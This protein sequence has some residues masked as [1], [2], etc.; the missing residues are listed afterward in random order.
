MHEQP[1]DKDARMEEFI[2][3]ELPPFHFDFGEFCD[4]YGEEFPAIRGLILYHTSA[5][6]ASHGSRACLR[7][8]VLNNQR[9]AQRKE[10]IAGI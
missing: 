7:R 5:P 3:G 2:I 6:Y 9:E 4:Y 8:R 10:I 1:V